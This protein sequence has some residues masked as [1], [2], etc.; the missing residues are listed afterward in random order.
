MRRLLI[1]GVVALLAALEAAA[2]TGGDGGCLIE[3]VKS[4]E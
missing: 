2:Q 1:A 3:A 4:G